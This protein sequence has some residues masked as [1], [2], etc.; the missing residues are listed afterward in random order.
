MVVLVRLGQL[1]PR[2]SLPSLA[3]WRRNAIAG[4]VVGVIALPLSIALAVAVGVPPIAGLYT[5]VFAGGLASLCG[6]SRFNITGP[7][8]ALVPVLSGAVLQHGPGALPM[9][10]LL[11]GVL[12]LAMSLLGAGRLVRFI[13]HPV[14]IG[15]TAGIALSIA[16]GQL[17]TFL[18]VT[19][20]D[21]HR[22]HFHEKLWDTLAHLGT[23]EPVTP[24]MGVAALVLLFCWQ[25]FV[26]RV[27][28]P[29]VAVTGF[30]ALTWWLGLD[31]PTLGSRYGELP[32][33][34]PTPSFAWF[35]AGLA[36]DLIPVAVAVAVLGAVESLL[37]AVVG[38]GM[39]ASSERT[40]PDRELFGQ[41][42]ANVISPIM[43][44]IPATAAIARTAAGIRNGASSRL[45][46]F[47]H[48]LTVL[49]ATLAFG[50]LAGHIPLT[51]LAAVLI[52]VA[53]NIAEADVLAALVRRAPR[54]DLIVLISTIAI[55]LFFDL[56]YAIGFGVVVSMVL[57]IRRLGSDPAA[58]AMLADDSGA[59]AGVSPELGALIHARPDIAFYNARGFLSFHSA[60]QFEHELQA[61]GHHRP[62]ILRTKDV[63]H[64]DTSGLLALREVIRYHRRHGGRVILTAIQP[65]VREVLERFGI[66]AEI[67]PANVFEHTKDAIESIPVPARGGNEHGG[68]ARHAAA[69]AAG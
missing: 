26:P 23:V 44:G 46:G 49:L 1:L 6:G 2:P 69:D 10:G 47:F 12:L 55:T 34:F 22:E 16:F 8:A 4:L 64:I 5:A 36:F 53:W 37:A 51:V 45:T 9:V 50:G 48:A 13:P 30:T 43:G 66:L 54:E 14:I 25:R 65:E 63:R 3:E 24:L 58:A 59:V 19:G 27:P 40:E 35:D 42:V 60:A 11:A 41:A 52:V 38:D 56:T 31:T 32:R 18:A 7:T 67:D 39:A 61:S 17:N 62:L 15:F 57:L 68:I 21:P 29:L 28:G 33:D 20:T